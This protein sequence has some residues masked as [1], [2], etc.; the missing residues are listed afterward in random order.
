VAIVAT[1]IQWLLSGGAA[2]TSAAAS[3]GG[4]V[5]ST[6]IIDATANNLFDDVAGAEATAGDTEYRGFYIKN[7]H[8]SLAL[9]NTKIYISALTS[10]ASTEFDIGLATEAVNTSMATIADETTAPAGVTFSRP[11]D[12][13]AGLA[14]G[15]LNA[16]DRKGIW[17]RRTV[18][19]GASPASDAGTL[20][21]EGDS[22]P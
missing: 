19:A 1:D 13:T 11:V 6:G 7:N 14:I 16:G 17:I 4:A 9:S 15:T 20:K 10:S 3:L 8:G 12:Y 2:N 21:V 18:T 5:S 22:P